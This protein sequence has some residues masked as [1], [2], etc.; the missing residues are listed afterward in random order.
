MHRVN[1]EKGLSTHSGTKRAERVRGRCDA[2]SFI[3]TRPRKHFFYEK[4]KRMVKKKESSNH[5]SG[6]LMST[7]VEICKH[8]HRREANLYVYRH[9]IWETAKRTWEDIAWIMQMSER[10]MRFRSATHKKLTYFSVHRRMHSV[11]ITN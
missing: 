3:H 1:H 5:V 11:C 2:H 7:N 10:A 4:G 9:T 8:H 6:S